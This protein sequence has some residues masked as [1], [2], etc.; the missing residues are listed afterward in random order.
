MLSN[1]FMFENQI[2]SSR[3]QQKKYFIIACI[4]IFKTL[5]SLFKITSVCYVS[6]ILKN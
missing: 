2:L 1:Q 4:V 6:D 5:M 3:E